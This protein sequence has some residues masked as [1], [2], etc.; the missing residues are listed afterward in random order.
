MFPPTMPSTAHKRPTSFPF[1]LLALAA[2]ADTFDP[3]E[4]GP[5]I[6]STV[7]EN[8]S[9]LL[10]ESGAD[11]IVTVAASDPSGVR[12]VRLFASPAGGPPSTCDATL[13][14]GTPEHGTWRCVFMLGPDAAR[15]EWRVERIEASAL[16]GATTVVS[17]EPPL[18]FSVSTHPFLQ[19]CENTVLA[20]APGDVVEL[21]GGDTC[22]TLSGLGRYAV[23]F[24]DT[25]AT[26]RGRTGDDATGG[27]TSKRDGVRWS[28][29]TDLCSSSIRCRCS[30][31]HSS[32]G[33][34]SRASA[35]TRSCWSSARSAAPATSAG[36]PSTC[37]LTSGIAASPSSRW[38]PMPRRTT[39]SSP[40]RRTRSRGS[41]WYASSAR[42]IAGGGARVSTEL[43]AGSAGYVEVRLRVEPQAPIGL[44][45]SVPGVRWAITRVE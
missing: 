4:S 36:S 39:P 42:L 27:A 28:T 38:P 10:T 33:R 6:G 13:L 20:L 31:R 7:V 8:E 12:A 11:A 43:I 21:G 30:R 1:L 9:V 23:A 34:S 2:C 40:S 18:S 41:V 32:T 29:G 26:T 45:A 24:L 44:T 3:T 37:F 17:P 14:D 19:R 25:R 22:V 5:R 35:P 16:T 15:G